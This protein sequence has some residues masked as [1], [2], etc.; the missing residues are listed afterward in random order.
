MSYVDRADRFDAEV[1]AAAGSDSQLIALLGRPG[2]DYRERIKVTAALGDSGTG[3]E[4]SAAVRAQFSDAMT[5]LAA[6]D[7]ARHWWTDLACAAVWA[8]AGR[9]G[10]RPATCTWRRPGPQPATCASTA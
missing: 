1:D 10:R 5:G 4:G 3:P 2:L 7:S 6:S 8:L 9:E